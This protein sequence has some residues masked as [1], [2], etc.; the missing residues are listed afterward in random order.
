MSKK[1]APSNSYYRGTRNR[2]SCLHLRPDRPSSFWLRR[3]AKA[4]VDTAT[5]FL[6]AWE[7][8][9]FIREKRR[10]AEEQSSIKAAAYTVTNK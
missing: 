9:K 4:D 7:R 5:F 8:E 10:L 6:F 1:T 2:S 3:L